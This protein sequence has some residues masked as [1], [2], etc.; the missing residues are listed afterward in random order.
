MEIKEIYFENMDYSAAYFQSNEIRGIIKS[1]YKRP[2]IK[3]CSKKSK[4]YIL[5]KVRSKSF[6]GLTKNSIGI[7]HVSIIELKL[8]EGDSVEISSAN[9]IDRNINYLRKNPNEDIRIAWLLFM[10]SILLSILIFFFNFI[11]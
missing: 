3:I 10:T 7:D 9:F 11:D 8:K 1:H 4:T 5:R 6:E 2:I